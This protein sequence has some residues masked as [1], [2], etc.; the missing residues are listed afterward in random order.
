MLSFIFMIICI[1]F[2]T[3]L[4]HHNVQVKYWPLAPYIFEK[5]NKTTGMLVKLMEKLDSF[6]ENQ[7]QFNMSATFSKVADT[8][9]S[10]SEL[11]LTASVGSDQLMIWGPYISSQTTSELNRQYQGMYTAVEFFKGKN[12]VVVVDKKKIYLLH[13]ILDSLII[14]STVVIILLVMSMYTGILIWIIEHRDNSEFHQSFYK[15]A[16]TGVWWSFVTLMTVGYGDVIPKKLIGRTLAIF[17]IIY[18]VFN[19][20]LM[21]ALITDSIFGESGISISKKNVSVLNDSAEERIA[22]YDFSATVIKANSYED[23]IQNLKNKNIFAALIKEDVAAWVDPS[24]I[25]SND[26][27][28]VVLR[29]QREFSIN[30]L[31][32]RNE[33]LKEYTSCFKAFEKEQYTVPENMFKK[34]LQTETVYFP[35]WLEYFKDTYLQ[36]LFAVASCVIIFALIFD[37]RKRKIKNGKYILPQFN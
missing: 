35:R 12:M 23:V 30:F 28:A 9:A 36:S 19:C 6:C 13:K 2:S 32:T 34:V 26:T 14:N 24:I 21:I 11:N 31:I 16:G 33:F 7:Y 8:R 4:S 5:N 29:Y 15:G 18:G 3:V 20:N 1:K 22:L 10:F 25:N 27:L 17:Y 37:M